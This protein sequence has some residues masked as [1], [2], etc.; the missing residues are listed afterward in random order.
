MSY[1]LEISPDQLQAHRNMR[2]FT[3][4]IEFDPE[5]SLYVGVV[6]DVSGAHSQG[7]TLDELYANLREVL[8]LCLDESDE[9]FDKLPRFA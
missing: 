3:A 7:V 8:E 9:P 1:Q 2:T 5:T 4:Y 6:P